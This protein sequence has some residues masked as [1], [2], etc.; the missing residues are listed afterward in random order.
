MVVGE[1][2]Q[3]VDLVVVGGGPGGYTAAL[4]AAELGLKT[5]LVDAQTKPGGVCLHMGC[6]P[7]KSL[8]HAAEIINESKH[9]EKIGLK[10]TP[11]QIDLDSLRGWKQGVLDKLAS[12]IVGMCK[13]AGV[14]ILHGKAVFNDSRSIR[15]DCPG[16]SAVRVKF[17]QCI[18]A[19][20]SRPSQ[21]PK[22]FENSEAMNSPRVM[23]ST[24]ALKL[25]DIPKDL[26]V[27]GG[28]Y[29]G[30]ELG[31]V[32]ASLGSQVTVVEMTDGLLPGADRDLVKPLATKLNTQFKAIYLNTK[33]TGIKV[34]ANSVEA[35]LEGKDVPT[36]LKFDK[37]LVAVGRRPNSDNIGLENT[38][39]EIDQFG[40][41][42]QDQECRTR[43][44]RILAIGDVAGQPML[45]HRAMRQG[46]VAAEVLAGKK[47][48]FDNACIPCVVFTQPEIAWVGLTE[49]EA[50]AKSITISSAKFPWSA[51]G[52]AMTLADTNG[53]TKVLFNPDNGLVLGV[54][55]AGPRAGDL[56]SEA[57][58][59]IEMGATLEDL[60]L[61]IHPHPTLSETI[62]EAA[63]SG[64]ARMERQK[65]KEQDKQVLH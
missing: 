3:E 59:A 38:Q 44:K 37:V 50:K 63:I 60:A 12:G 39:V 52:R 40:F 53:T 32:Y 34:T 56:I 61:S 4:R 6:I 51:S 64:M 22:L 21:L 20:G 42:V 31:S 14:D 17:K 49:G 48:L 29:I 62:N 46:Y 35:I 28:G 43:D 7:S 54:G 11:P 45:A 58:L 41:V 10:F 47:S 27:L 8:L 26:L 5:L 1:M 36:S 18:L 15:V 2:V 24:S 57:V 55:M 19:T 9:A 13:A 16:E 30:L 33:V 23:D 25:E 65:A